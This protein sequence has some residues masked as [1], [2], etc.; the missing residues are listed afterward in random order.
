MNYLKGWNVLKIIW[1]HS[2]DGENFNSDDFETRE[3]CIADATENYGYTSFY[4][5]QAV[6]FK[7]HIYIDDLLERMN[8][9]AC[10]QC[11]EYAENYLYYVSDKDKKELSDK[12]NEVF[13]AWAKKTG[14]EPTFFTVDNVEK[15]E[16][17]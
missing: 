7:P 13:Q 2:S 15:I 11:G 4:I 8:E 1:C 3:D 17:E 5:G 6:D 9:Q 12:L 16:V 10:E 14:N